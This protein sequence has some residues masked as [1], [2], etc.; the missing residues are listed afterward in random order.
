MELLHA[1][2]LTDRALWSELNNWVSLTEPGQA[3]DLQP[4]DEAA[5]HLKAA[6]E[7]VGTDIFKLGDS[8]N[9][10][11]VRLLLDEP[12]ERVAAARKDLLYGTKLNT[13]APATFSNCRDALQR[14][15][16]LI[17]PLLSSDGLSAAAKS[18]SD[19]MRDSL[20]DVSGEDTPPN[21]RTEALAT[22]DHQLSA[23]GH[24][25]SSNWG[26]IAAAVL[27]AVAA[28]LWIL[29]LVKR[30]AWASDKADA[31]AL[32]SGQP[33]SYLVAPGPGDLTEAPGQVV[34]VQ[35]A[36]QTNPFVIASLIFGV[37]GGWGL[38]IIFGHV[39]RSQ[40]FKTGQGGAGM[41]LAGLIL[42]YL[43]LA[44]SIAAVVFFVV[45]AGSLG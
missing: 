41:A 21:P 5:Q 32:R 22:L 25:D 39:A 26:W 4:L 23:S 31:I 17:P 27:T 9:D 13:K 37:I 40:I 8:E 7:D 36:P 35:A 42:G 14:A 2:E 3:P 24:K 6:A 12:D 28:G 16:E 43:S 11:Q 45:F 1:I 18:Y 19:S 10:L 44:V 20:P 34:V 38:A 15:A 33:A 29:L 30:D